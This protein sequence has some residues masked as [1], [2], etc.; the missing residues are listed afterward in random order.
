MAQIKIYGVRERLDPIKARMSDI[1]HSC[2]VDALQFPEDKRAHRFFPLAREDFYFPGGRTDAYTIIEVA[3]IEGRTSET[4]KKLVKLLFERISA[5][6]PITP[7]DLEI[8]IL[9][10]P[11]VNWGFRGKCG[12]EIE[13]TYKIEV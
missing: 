5:A 8:N 12:D 7:M 1:V 13:L 11:K 6:L 10:A 9:E 2:V 4:K 3:M